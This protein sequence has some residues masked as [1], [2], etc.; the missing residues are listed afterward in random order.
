MSKQM[1]LQPVWLPA[2]I[3]FTGDWKVFVETIYAVF[4]RDFKDQ[5]PRFR[6]K[7]I[8]HDRRVLADG[9]EKEEGFWHLV[10][11]DKWVW[12]PQTRRKEK[13]RL[14]DLDRA[15]RLPWVRPIIEHETAPDVRAWDYDEATKS[16]IAVRTYV[17]L[18]DY[19]YVVVLEKQARAKGDIFQLITSFHVSY[20][21]KRRDLESRY[22]RRKK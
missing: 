10:T 9:D 4:T 3:P 12:N 11:Q 6:A 17:W 13:E 8:W 21:S 14:P 16:G 18:T 19:D 22:E 15:G 2:A 5:R 1:D 7:P 20:E